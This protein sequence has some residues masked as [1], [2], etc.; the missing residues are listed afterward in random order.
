V[1]L[2]VTNKMLLQREESL[3]MGVGHFF[4]NAINQEQGNIIVNG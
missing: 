3:I 1:F 2:V 4:S